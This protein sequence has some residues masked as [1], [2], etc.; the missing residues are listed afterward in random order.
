MTQ[1]KDIKEKDIKTHLEP[2][3]PTYELVS[4]MPTNYKEYLSFILA[5]TG[6]V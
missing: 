6:I 2:M 1:E 4:P 3:V 5:S